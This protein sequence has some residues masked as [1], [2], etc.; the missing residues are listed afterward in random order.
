M[1]RAPKKPKMER[2]G[3]AT[4][5]RSKRKLAYAVRVRKNPE[6]V[7][8]AQDLGPAGTGY[9]SERQ[10]RQVAQTAADAGV[11]RGNQ[12]YLERVRVS[13]AAQ[14]HARETLEAGLKQ[15]VTA[16]PKRPGAVSNPGTVQSLGFRKDT[17]SRQSARTW[18]KAHGYRW[19]DRDVDETG[20]FYWMRQA[21]PDRFARIRTIHLTRGVEARMGYGTARK[22]PNASQHRASAVKMAAQVA[23]APDAATRRYFEGALAAH[24]GDPRANPERSEYEQILAAASRIY[25]VSQRDLRKVIKPLSGDVALYGISHEQH[26][27]IPD[28]F[29]DR[30]SWELHERLNAAMSKIIGRRVYTESQNAGYSKVYYA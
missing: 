24:A 16:G 10:A 1:K 6:G 15:P 11:G 26:P 2:R 3:G 28:A 14:R 27:G 21:E 7:I 22:N 29:R 8:V 30:R 23:G 20:A 25:R 19:V 17:F 13:R 12:V 4:K 9:P 5:T 18:A